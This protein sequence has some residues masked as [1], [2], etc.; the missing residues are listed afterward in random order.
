MYRNKSH[1]VIAGRSALVEELEQHSCTRRV[2]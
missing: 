2:E 1:G